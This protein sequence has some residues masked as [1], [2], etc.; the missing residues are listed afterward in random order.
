MYATSIAGNNIVSPQTET[1]RDVSGLHLSAASRSAL[2]CIQCGK[3]FH[4]V[5]GLKLHKNLHKGLYR[6]K[7]HFC[8]RGFSGTTNLRGH[9][10]KH[11]GIKEFRCSI[12]LKE[13]SYAHE[14]RRHVRQHHVAT[15]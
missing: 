4:S 5:S 11:T 2:Q 8:G 13:Y 10:V 7:C 14:L 1:G 9:M 6:Y 12:C 3:S 15:E